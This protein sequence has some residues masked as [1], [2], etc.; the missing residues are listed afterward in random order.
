MLSDI[1]RKVRALVE[2]FNI[3]AS[4][5]FIYTLSS[6]FR[7]CSSNIS[8]IELVTVN[9]SELGSADYSFNTTIGQLTIYSHLVDGDIIDV[10]FVYNKYSESEI[11][12]YITSSLVYISTLTNCADTDFELEETE[13]YPTPSN[14]EEDLIALIAG[15]IIN[16]NYSSY[17]LPNVRVSYPN[18]MSKIDRIT[19][20]I[21]GFYRS[22]GVMSNIVIEWLG[23]V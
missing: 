3:S 21:K 11:E 18:E 9:G 7:V 20:T 19:K 4:E 2:D 23:N 12:G 22:S 13:I 1:K 16:P 17:S 15:I 6:I 10:S 5:Q 14:K 8:S